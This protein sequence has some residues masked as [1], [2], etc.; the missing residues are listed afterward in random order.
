MSLPNAR[1]DGTEEPGLEAPFEDRYALAGARRLAKRAAPIP[2]RPEMPPNVLC[3][4]GSEVGV[5]VGSKAPRAWWKFWR[6]R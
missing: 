4:G 5:P 3:R 6:S 2:P 1:A